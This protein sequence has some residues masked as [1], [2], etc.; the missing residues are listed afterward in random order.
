MIT[1]K[2]KIMTSNC[3]G[4]EI[5]ND[6][7]FHNELCPKCGEHCEIEGKPDLSY[8]ELLEVISVKP[9]ETIL[10]KLYQKVKK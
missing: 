7:D 8:V 3:C 1:Q 9:K 2:N 6:Y 4:A 10:S 5:L